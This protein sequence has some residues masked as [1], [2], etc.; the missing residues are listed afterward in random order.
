M[1]S[2]KC[3]VKEALSD[4]NPSCRTQWLQKHISQATL[5]AVRIDNMHLYIYKILF[6]NSL[7]LVLVINT[8][9]RYVYNEIT[10]N[11]HG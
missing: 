3:E 7:Q 6:Q 1:D 11:I 9:F 2:V 8:Q 4:Y 5:T 10:R